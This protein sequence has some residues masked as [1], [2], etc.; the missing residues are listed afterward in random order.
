MICFCRKEEP[1]ALAPEEKWIDA[2]PFRTRYLEAGRPDAPTV[3]LLHDGAW[4]GASSVTWSDII[5]RLAEHYHVLAPDMLGFGGSDKVVFVDRAQYQPRMRQMKWLLEA[6]GIAEPIHVAGN[7]FGGSLALKALADGK[8]LA[9]RS[10]TSICGTGG[11]W[12]GDA[13]PAEL[14]HWDGTENDLR[15][16]VELL[17]DADSPVFEAQLAER[18]KWASDPGHYRAV[19]AVSTPLPA[20][21]VRARRVDEWPRELEGIATPVMLVAGKRDVLLQPYWP[22]RLR[23]ALPHARVEIMD[24]RHSPNIDQGDLVAAVLLDF[25][26][27]C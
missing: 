26:G 19:K 4:G 11:A 20:S 12:K 7:S 22:E 3:L 25:F 18:L 27:G 1:V 13:S 24:S 2:G 14:P 16:I 6:L 5:P 17:I 10:V 15:R 8:T 23:T 9:I 21:L